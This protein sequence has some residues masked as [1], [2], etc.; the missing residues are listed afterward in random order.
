MDFPDKEAALDWIDANQLGR[1]N[2]N[3]YQRAEIA[4][5]LEDILKEQAK[6]RQGT[7]TDLEPVHDIPQNSAES[8]PVSHVVAKL[9]PRQERETRAVVAKT[10]GVSHDTIK[11][12]KAIRDDAIAEK[13]PVIQAKREIKE[14]P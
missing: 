5:Q 1:R 6:E 13:R 10:A 11:K 2:L 14:A 9:P 7:R 8:E 3:D 12:V 4:L